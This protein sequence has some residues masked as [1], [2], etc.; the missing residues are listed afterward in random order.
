MTPV[1]PAYAGEIFSALKDAGIDV[2]HFFLK[3]PREVLEKRIDGRSFTPDD[4]E[5]DERIRRWCKDRIEPCMAGADTLPSDTV[6]LDGELT[7]QELADQV[8]ARI[9]AGGQAGA[10]LARWPGQTPL[11]WNSAASTPRGVWPPTTSD[12]TVSFSSGLS[13]AQRDDR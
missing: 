2:H 12:Q 5:Q 11:C 1:D 3:V 13:A 10:R 7:P 8:R 4:P 6:V 9:R